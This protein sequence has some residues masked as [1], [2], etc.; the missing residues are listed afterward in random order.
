MHLFISFIMRAFMALLKDNLY[1]NGVDFGGDFTQSLDGSVD[2][3]RLL[4]DR[5]GSVSISV[6][7]MASKAAIMRT[8]Y[9][10]T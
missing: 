7:W 3:A 10:L 5:T 2:H 1:L 6:F 4:E 9:D 8:T